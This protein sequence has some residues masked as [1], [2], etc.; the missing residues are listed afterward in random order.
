METK[1]IKILFLIVLFFVSFSLCNNNL[2][3]QNNFLTPTQ[4]SILSIKGY[5]S[6]LE[7][8]KTP[9]RSS[10]EIPSRLD[11]FNQSILNYVKDFYNHDYYSDMISQDASH[12]VEFLQ[13]S[14]ELNFNSSFLYTGLRLIYNK[15][16]SCEFIND[17][18]IL[19]TL[20]NLPEFLSK[21]F[22]ED[23]NNINFVSLKNDIEKEI[24]YK[25]TNNFDQIKNKPKEF[26][27][28][29]SEKINL[30]AKEEINNWEKDLN[31]QESS[32]RLREMVIKLLE[33]TLNKAVWDYTTP[34]TIWKSFGKISRGIDQVGIKGII[35]QLD[36]IDDLQWSL[37]YR[38][39]FFLDFA[40]SRLPLS[41]YQEIETDLANKAVT[42]LEATEQDEGIKT[43]K[44]IL[45]QALLKAK[46]KAVAFEK[47][48]LY[49]E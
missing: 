19:Q 34:E 15:F 8:I 14:K 41:F 12:I 46:A 28:E 37:T 27:L 39:C 45:L 11:I 29:L 33:L 20:E 36:D 24:I 31:K 30:L 10:G 18:V 3:N 7:K 47:S 4:Y 48:G 40:G 25:L 5:F 9:T 35:D 13:M 49:I 44:T 6:N 2:I 43:K 17:I 21:Y 26:A 1:S 42:F 32:N 16:K 22:D 38:F 23:L